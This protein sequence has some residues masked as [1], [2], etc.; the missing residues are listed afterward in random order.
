MAWG[1]SKPPRAVRKAAEALEAA[2]QRQV[3]THQNSREIRQQMRGTAAA[4]QAIRSG[5]AMN[6]SADKNV[7]RAEKALERAAE[8][9]AKKAA[10]KAAKKAR[11]R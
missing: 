1:Q 10:A 11:G 5:N 6:R 8:S 7:R 9:A 4:H 3:D 2:Q